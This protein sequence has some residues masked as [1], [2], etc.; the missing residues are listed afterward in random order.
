MRHQQ[1]ESQLLLEQAQREAR[2]IVMKE[3]KEAR[4]K[5]ALEEKLINQQISIIRGQIREQR[6]STNK[7]AKV[8]R[9]AIETELKTKKVKKTE[10]E[11][12]KKNVSGGEQAG[13]ADVLLSSP[14]VV[15]AEKI[16]EDERK[17][18]QTRLELVRQLEKAE[19]RDLK[20]RMRLLRG[21][22]SAWYEEVIS[23]W[24][25]VRKAGAVRDWKLLGRAW[26][27]WHRWAV[28]RRNRREAAAATREMQR[29]MR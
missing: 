22:F 1:L 26:G 12:S 10:Q 2:E 23:S 4:K 27:A 9:M 24:G 13:L 6:K 29:N 15:M 5:A 16:V 11:G 25:K 28:H 7:L 14:T 8:Q 21:F 20:E 19:T 17:R 18:Q 3:E